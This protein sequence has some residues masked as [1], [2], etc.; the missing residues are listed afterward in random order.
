MRS[1]LC[2]RVVEYEVQVMEKEVIACDAKHEL[3]ASFQGRAL[4]EMEA[5]LLSC[6]TLSH[7]HSTSLHHLQRKS[8]GH[9]GNS[10]ASRIPIPV[11]YACAPRC[12]SLSQSGCAME[13]RRR[14][15]RSTVAMS[16][17]MDQGS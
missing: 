1:V 13:G 6:S 2:C 8:S 14:T 5:V 11:C 9:I 4:L 3:R 15:T 17:L 16:R 10:N 7:H 12:A